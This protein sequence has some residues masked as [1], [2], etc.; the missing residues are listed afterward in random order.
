MPGTKR[1]GDLNHD[2]DHARQTFTI[3]GTFPDPESLEH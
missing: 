3:L 2:S 1:A